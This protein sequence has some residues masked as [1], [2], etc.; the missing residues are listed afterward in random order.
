MEF[1]R[2]CGLVVRVSGYTS[3]GPGFDSRRY[4]IFREVVGLE[5]GPLGLMSTMEEL[6]GRNNSGSGL[7]NLQYGHGDLLRW[8]R[9]TLYLQ[10]LALTS[11]TSGGR[12][13]GII[14]LRAKATGFFVVVYSVFH[15]IKTFVISYRIFS[16]LITVDCTLSF[17]CNMNYIRYNQLP[18]CYFID[19]CGICIGVINIVTVFTFLLMLEAVLKFQNMSMLVHVCN[20]I[21]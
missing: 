19:I 15:T 12:K 11:P 3:R 20:E 13:I 21:K 1:Y 2:L 6:L 10:K 17:I 14:H 9:D 4:Q 8:P 16:L 5:Q 18:I 7:E